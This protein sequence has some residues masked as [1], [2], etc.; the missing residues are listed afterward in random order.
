MAD[1]PANKEF[2]I[3]GKHDGADTLRYELHENDVKVS[4]KTPADLV[5]IP[6]GGDTWIEFRRTLPA[7]TVTYTVW[8]F[9]PFEHTV[10]DPKM[11]VVVDPPQKVTEVTIVYPAAP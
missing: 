2:V 1:A 6:E 7:G 8:A 4:E 11:A 9:G 10:S 5:E 3:R